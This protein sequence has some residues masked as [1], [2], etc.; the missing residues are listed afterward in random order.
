MTTGQTPHRP[1]RP[2]PART[3]SG[4][5]NGHP[6]Q[7]PKILATLADLVARGHLRPTI[8]AAIDWQRTDRALAALRSGDATGKTVLTTST[9]GH[10]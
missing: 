2:A 5:P 3:M 1:F 10:A 6:H 7:Q 4:E 8:A 9:N